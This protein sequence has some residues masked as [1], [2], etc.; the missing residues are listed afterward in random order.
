LEIQFHK[1]F[2]K[3]KKKS[4]IEKQMQNPPFSSTSNDN[5]TNNTNNNNNKKQTLKMKQRQTIE[6]YLKEIGV[7]IEEEDEDLKQIIDIFV[8][9]KK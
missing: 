4:Q 5:N 3:N 2:N 1:T 7:E 6:E 8:D 9:Q